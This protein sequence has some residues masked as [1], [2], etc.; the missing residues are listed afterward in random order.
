MK[1]QILYRY[2]R[3]NGGTTVSP[4]VPESD[5]SY[6]ETIRLVA[7]EGKMLTNGEIIASC[8]DVDNTNGWSEIDKEVIED[9]R[10]VL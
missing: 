10:N 2:V 9:E 5:V 6:T 1:T 7:D 3:S 4:V 8:I